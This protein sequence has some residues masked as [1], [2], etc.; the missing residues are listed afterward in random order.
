MLGR[1]EACD[2]EMIIQVSSQFVPLPLGVDGSDI[3]QTIKIATS[4][5]FKVI[6]PL[7]DN[8]WRNLQVEVD[9]HLLKST[10]FHHLLVIY[11]LKPVM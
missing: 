2:V 7:L 8:S 5:R 6:H 3:I 11:R 1:P 9:E 10:S 4:N